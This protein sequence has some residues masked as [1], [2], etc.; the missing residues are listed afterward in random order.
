M[1]LK[2]KITV[3]TVRDVAEQKGQA[4]GLCLAQLP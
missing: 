1:N 4:G 2:H 3:K